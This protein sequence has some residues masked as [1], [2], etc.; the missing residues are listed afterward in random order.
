MSRKKTSPAF[1][2]VGGPAHALKRLPRDHE[3]FDESY[4]QE[5]L[6]AHPELL[7]VAE[8]REDA[9]TLVCIGREVGLS[10]YAIDNL[11]LSSGGYP[12]IVETKLWRN[13]EARREVLAQML[14]YIKEICTKDYT[15]FETQWEA[16]MKGRCGTTQTLLARLIEV[17]DEEIDESFIVDRV[18]RALSNGDVIGMVVGDGI[19]TRLQALVD[20][21]C[22]RTP[23]LRYALTLVEMACYE[24]EALGTSRLVVPRIVQSI[25]PVERA[26]IRIEV[27]P[28]LEKQLQ[29]EPQV[30]EPPSTRTG[31]RV[32]LTEDDFLRSVEESGG[33][34]CREDMQAF[35]RDLVDSFGLEPE[36]KGAS[37]MIKVPDPEEDRHGVSVLGLEKAGRVYNTQHLKGQLKRWGV[38]SQVVD[39][40]A[41]DYWAAL[42]AI[43]HRFDR[44]GI[45]HSAPPRFLPLGALREKLP[46]I[47]QQVGDVVAKI[48]D[49]AAKAI[50]RESPTGGSP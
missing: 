45:S 5:L 4:L 19:E 36:F 21:I 29:I 34:Q 7:P 42:N 41:R 28:Q 37:L 6:A 46:A 8:I 20:D 50:E 23:H 32:T 35:Y 10:S 26:Y 30:E 25:E 48:R 22:K 17:S 49:A 18:N 47:K 13:P 39:Q 14:E 1:V 38:E 44:N 43:D 16:N 27:A 9:G 11:Y 24:H 15:W 33:R 3:Q 2:V 12:V 40:L 31:L